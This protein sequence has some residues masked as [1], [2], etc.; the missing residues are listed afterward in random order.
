MSR[1]M[2]KI[3]EVLF[4]NADLIT[5]RFHFMKEI[6]D[7]LQTERK[8]LKTEFKKQDNEARIKEKKLKAQ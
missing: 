1:S 8:R 6:L 4:P 2:E 7:D 5:D 3:L